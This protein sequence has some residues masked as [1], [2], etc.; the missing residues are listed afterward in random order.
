[1]L[2]VSGVFRRA[3][4]G[5]AVMMLGSVLGANRQGGN[6]NKDEGEQESTEHHGG[7]AA[8]LTLLE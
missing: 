7:S 1:M 8:R 6:A 3:D 2:E 5:D 4:Q